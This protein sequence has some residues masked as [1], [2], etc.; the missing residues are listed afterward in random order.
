M[1]R[2]QSGRRPADRRSTAVRLG[3]ETRRGVFVSVG[4]LSADITDTPAEE[5]DG[6]E[7]DLGDVSEELSAL[8]DEYF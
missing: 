3:C 2:S 7:S 4:V 8:V 6:I 1:V 5:L